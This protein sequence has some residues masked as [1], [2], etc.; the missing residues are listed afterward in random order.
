MNTIIATV[1]EM[2]RNSTPL[3]DGLDAVCSLDLEALERACKEVDPTFELSVGAQVEW[4]ETHAL[5]QTQLRT[6]IN[7]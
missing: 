2:I 6:S 7:T 4:D 1:K 5:R 3:G